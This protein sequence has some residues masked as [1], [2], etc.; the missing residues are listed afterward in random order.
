M[1][2][3]I[4]TNKGI[5]N[6]IQ[7]TSILILLFKNA[8]LRGESGHV[9]RHLM[10]MSTSASVKLVSRTSLHNWLLN[11]HILKNDS[12][13]INIIVDDLFLFLFKRPHY[14]VVLEKIMA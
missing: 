10:R 9:Q 6:Y 3:S 13:H 14:V 5:G 11:I 12:E 8:H 4:V 1:S 7:L 2:Q